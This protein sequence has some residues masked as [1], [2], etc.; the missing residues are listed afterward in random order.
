MLFCRY[1]QKYNKIKNIYTFIFLDDVFR[2][3]ERAFIII[4]VSIL[5]Y[6]IFLTNKIIF[7]TGTNFFSDRYAGFKSRRSLCW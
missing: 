7:I 3:K 2:I 4:L 5:F 6:F 1:V